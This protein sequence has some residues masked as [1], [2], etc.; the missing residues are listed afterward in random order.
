MGYLE[1]RSATIGWATW[2]WKRLA[3]QI[4]TLAIGPDEQPSP[5]FVNIPIPSGTGWGHLCYVYDP[6]SG[7]QSY[8]ELLCE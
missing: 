1:L 6:G 4:Q 7:L 2:P 8:G 5:V 3:T